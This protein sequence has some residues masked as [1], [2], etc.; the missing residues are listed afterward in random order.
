MRHRTTASSYVRWL[1]LE[2]DILSPRPG[3]GMYWEVMKKIIFDEDWFAKRYTFLPQDGIWSKG[4]MHR[5]WVRRNLDLLSLR[6]SG[7]MLQKLNLTD[8]TWIDVNY[9]VFGIE[10]ALLFLHGLS[11]HL[12]ECTIAYLSIGNKKIRCSEKGHCGRSVK[13]HK[14]KSLHCCNNL[15]AP[16]KHNF[17]I[18][19]LKIT[20]A[21]TRRTIL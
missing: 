10:R 13:A 8:E 11:K 16:W 20:F 1:A 12:E 15:P 6:T 5:P 18:T 4:R 14:G 9:S 7:S 2:T 17:Q 21:P 3:W 19:D